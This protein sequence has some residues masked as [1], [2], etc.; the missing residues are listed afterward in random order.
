MGLLLIPAGLLGAFGVLSSNSWMNTPGGVTLNATGRLVNVDALAALFTRALPYEFWHFVIAIYLTAGFLVASIYAV[1]WLRGRRDHYQRL[2][3][4]VPFTIAA[5]LAPVE[6]AV[7]DL[8]A[9]GLVTDQ[10]SK[11]A[12][13]EI[14]W[15]TRS[16]NP[17]VI[18]GLLND[19]GAVVWGIAIPSLDSILVG[20]SPDSVA[21]GLSSF[22]PD[23]RPSITEANITHLAFDLMV[24]LGIAGAGLAAWYFLVLIRRR[25]LPQSRWFYRAASLAGVGAYAAVE[26]GWVTTEVGRQPWIVYDAMR[27]SDAVTSAPAVFIWT[28]LTVLVVVYAVIAVIFVTLVRNLAARWRRD[29]ASS[30]A[31]TPEMGVPYGPRVQA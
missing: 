13:M 10:P 16:H 3:F 30:V 23:S 26:S 31:E 15:K 4:A 28:M 6:V 21:P 17:E 14:N 24:G 29:D 2:A 5:L 27:V 1:A 22:A 20:Y 12:A 7:G 11:F 9:R 18:G 19:S 8:S 25:D